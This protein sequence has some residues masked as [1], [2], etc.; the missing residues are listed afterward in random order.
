M[1][2]P[3]ST[4]LHT[5]TPPSKVLTW[6]FWSIANIFPNPTGNQEL[7][8]WHLYQ[9]H[10]VNFPQLMKSVQ[11]RC[12]A[13]TA[14]NVR[15][16]AKS[17]W[18]DA[19]VYADFA[20]AN[21]NPV[22]TELAD[23]L[24][25][26][27]VLYRGRPSFRKAG[28]VQAKSTQ[29][30]KQFDSGCCNVGA[31]DSSNKERDLLESHIGS[32][33]LHASGIGNGLS[34]RNRTAIPQPGQ[35]IFDVSTDQPTPG[36]GPYQLID[37]AT[38]LLFPKVQPNP[39][40]DEPYQVLTPSGRQLPG[41][42]CQ[43]YEDW[44]AD[45]ADPN[46]AIPDLQQRPR[47]RQLVEGVATWAKMQQRAKGN[48][49]RVTKKVPFVVNN[50]SSTFLLA[51]A[52]TPAPMCM[53]VVVDSEDPFWPYH[54]WVE[55]QSNGPSDTPPPPPAPKDDEPRH[56]FWLIQMYVDYDMPEISPVV[57]QEPVG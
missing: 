26:V 7:E 56:G 10:A 48:F 52:S 37:Y 32:I 16:D 18:V 15:I 3:Q 45:L 31:D 51:T 35:N 14:H 34:P 47:W 20:L 8:R 50:F 36:R 25:D 28:L 46:S 40:V 2:H 5:T 9:L 19:K 43:D 57:L 54:C 22:S 13:R 23:L 12:S 53:R 27:T 6:Q 38:Y 4:G 24:I 39:P 41:G 17:M 42:R 55:I 44:L 1:H 11:S 29:H 49:K 30:C 21:G 33:A